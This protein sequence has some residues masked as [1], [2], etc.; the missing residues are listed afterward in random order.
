MQCSHAKGNLLCKSTRSIVLWTRPQT[1][2]LMMRRDVFSCFRFTCP[3]DFE[4]VNLKNC[5][6]WSEEV[7]GPEKELW[8]VRVPEGVNQGAGT[9][10]NSNL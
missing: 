6:L 2:A 1:D 4:E 5:P 8:L 9:R 7:T 3:K 10:E